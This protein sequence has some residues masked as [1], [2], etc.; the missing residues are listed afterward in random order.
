[1][2]KRRTEINEM[3]RRFKETR[4]PELRCRLIEHYVKLVRY[5]AER[6]KQKLPQKVDLQ[7]MISA[8][9][10]G[11]INAVDRY[12]P[13]RGILFETYCSMRIRG[14]ILDDLRAADWVPRLIR[15][16]ANRLARAKTELAFELGREP[17]EAEIRARLGLSPSEFEELLRET[18]VRTQLPIEGAH[19]EGDDE[20]IQQVD[21]IEDRSHV[22]PLERLS[23]GELREVVSRGLSEKERYVIFMYYFR[24]RTMREIGNDLGVTESRVCQIHTQVLKLLRKRWKK[25]YKC[26]SAG[27]ETAQSSAA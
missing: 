24:N 12:D 15:N 3:W 5:T 10:I 11:L 4:D 13:D 9:M 18:E 19:T 6:L 17:Q 14:A 25:D 16:K 26:G 20:D 27:D 22:H 23:L 2:S 21:L 8:G 7:E 1:V